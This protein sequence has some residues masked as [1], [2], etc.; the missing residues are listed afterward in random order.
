[1]FCFTVLN[2]LNVTASHTK[3]RESSLIKISEH[4]KQARVEEKRREDYFL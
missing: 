3:T 1:M 2:Q 4:K